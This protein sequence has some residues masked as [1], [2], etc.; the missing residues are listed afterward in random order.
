[1]YM[2][3]EKHENETDRHSVHDDCGQ[4]RVQCG[5]GWSH[6]RD[7]KKRPVFVSLL[8]GKGIRGAV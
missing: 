1:M 4:N 8:I 6:D 3:W 5:S 2:I 7:G